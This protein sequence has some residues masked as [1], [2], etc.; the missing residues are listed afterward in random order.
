MMSYSHEPIRKVTKIFV[1]LILVVTAALS[2][3]L[4][5]PAVEAAAH[6]PLLAGAQVS[7]RAL[8]TLER[9]CQNCHSANTAWPWYASVP[10]V[11][12]KV[13]G[14][15]ERARR[16]MD[17][18]KWDEYSDLE[19]L[20]FLAGIEA[21]VDSREMPPGGYVWMHP[22]ARLAD[23][24]LSALRSWVLAEQQRIKSARGLAGTQ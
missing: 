12:W 20:G 5:R 21:A 7:P 24:D 8:A 14:D 3:L 16:F 15:V 9:A 1:L 10:P 19:K 13:H 6:K 17:F 11:S 23:T 2:L 4:A 18:S 22:E